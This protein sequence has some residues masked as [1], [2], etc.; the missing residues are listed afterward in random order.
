MRIGVIVDP[1]QNAWQLAEWAQLAEKYG[2]Q[3]FWLSNL[4]NSKDPF[5]NLTLA[6]ANTQTIELG[7]IAL[8]PYE[9]HP[10]MMTLSLMTLNEIAQGR[11]VIAVGGGGANARNI[12]VNFSDPKKIRRLTATG[13]CVEIITQIRTGKPV[14][15]QGRIFQV[16][17]FQS[18][19]TPNPG[20]VVYVAADK[21]KMLHMACAKADGVMISD[22]PPVYVDRMV[23]QIREGLARANRA[24]ST[25]RINNFYAWHVQDNYKDALKEAKRYLIVRGITR[26]RIA[27]AIGLNDEE[28]DL[29]QRNTQS[30]LQYLRT[31]AQPREIPEEILDKAAEGITIVGQTSRLEDCVEQLQQ[32]ERKGLNEIALRVYGDASSALKIIGEKVVPIFA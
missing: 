32:F 25:F 4:T 2:I 14:N 3:S 6:A 17:G 11:A 7:P 9:L 21:P 23:N 24:G 10:L 20:P 30:L 26:P 8:S 16:K 15:Y 28:F 12:G 19:W 1:R 31:G 29:I 22:V 27:R 13:E 5:V 18:S